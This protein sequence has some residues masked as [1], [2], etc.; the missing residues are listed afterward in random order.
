MVK[1]ETDKGTD[2]YKN[3]DEYAIVSGFL[4]IMVEDGKVGKKVATY[5]PGSWI[6]VRKQCTEEE[7][8]WIEKEE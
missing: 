7:G 8:P 1:V 4:R 5:A 3:A 6:S 2:S